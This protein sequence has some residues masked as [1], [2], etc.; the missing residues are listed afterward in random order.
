MY[1]ILTK[2]A[3][4]WISKIKKKKNSGSGFRMN[5]TFNAMLNDFG[6]LYF[7][8]LSFWFLIY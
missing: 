7:P 2:I 5:M 8:Y 1:I 4:W 3:M 6:T